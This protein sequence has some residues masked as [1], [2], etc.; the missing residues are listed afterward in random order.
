[1][2]EDRSKAAIAGLIVG[3][4]VVASALAIYF[5]RSRGQRAPDIDDVVEKARLTVQKLDEAVES[6]RASASRD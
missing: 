3:A 4:A 5:A 2:E 6:L 1:M